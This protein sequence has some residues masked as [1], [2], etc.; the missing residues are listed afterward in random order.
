MDQAGASRQNRIETG[1]M[2]GNGIAVSSFPVY[3]ATPL[4]QNH[5]KRRGAVVEEV[6]G[7]G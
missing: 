4:G 7:F 3:R 6:R 2:R 1:P 5:D